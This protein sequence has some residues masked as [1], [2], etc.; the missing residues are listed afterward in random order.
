MPV[1]FITDHAGVEHRLEGTAN[2]DVMHLARG[3]GLPVLG[4]C[5][6]S[7]A[8]GTCHVVI[9]AEWVSRLTPPDADEQDLL[10][11][12]FTVT[13]TSRLGCQIRLAEALDGLRVTIA[14]PD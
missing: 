3:A 13:P 12:L 10:D 2:D 9:D 4:E 6:G 14:E 8:C 1:L 7:M 11:S 5:N